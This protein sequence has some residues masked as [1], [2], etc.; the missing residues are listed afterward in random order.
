MLPIDFK[1][2]RIP[3]HREVNSQL[4]IWM[5]SAGYSLLED[6][7]HKLSSVPRIRQSEI[8][9]DTHYNRYRNEEALDRCFLYA[10][11]AENIGIV[12]LGKIDGNAESFP[13]TDSKIQS[14]AVI[15]LFVPN[16]HPSDADISTVQK[17]SRPCGGIECGN[18]KLYLLQCL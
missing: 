17:G 15:T 18:Y 3:A 11:D 4:E 13:N 10:E 8:K 9:E 7:R 12:G 5:F 6:C 14:I 16:I 1:P 2:I